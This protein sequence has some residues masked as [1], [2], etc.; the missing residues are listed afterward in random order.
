MQKADVAGQQTHDGS[1]APGRY[2]MEDHGAWRPSVK[3]TVATIFSILLAMAI[4]SLPRPALAAGA[5]RGQVSIGISV[6]FGPPPLPVYAQPYCPGP[7]YIWTPGYWAW[8][9]NTGYY[10]VPG[11]WVLAPFEGALWTPGYWGWDPAVALFMWHR[12]YWGTRVGFYG[13]IN[14]GFGYTGY[15]Y[16][17]GYWRDRHFYYN[18][19]VNRID[20]RRIR[21]VYDRRIDVRDESGISYNGGRGGIDA[22]PRRED[23]AARRY[24]R[25][26]PISSQMRQERMARQTP[27]MRW[28]QNRGRPDIAATP[29][30]EMFRDRGVSR[31]TRSGGE[32]RQ[33]Q[34]GFRPFGRQ[35]APQRQYRAP[36]QRYPQRQYQNQRPMNRNQGQ[37]QYHGPQRQ[38]QYRG[39]QGRPQQTQAPRSRGNQNRQQQQR[40]NRG[41]R[42]KGN[43]GRQGHPRN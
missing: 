21:R 35:P 42:G 7:G 4:V 31:A 43:Q 2:G 37:P 36:Q 38:P 9:A 1:E 39:Q 41:N 10:W 40:S 33:Q 3:I 22:R 16:D 20:V 19:A 28:S 11:T 13:G 25:M 27:G 24:R 6:G 17:G 30:P 12:G 15:G 26:G 32:Y 29:R 23:L 8:D 5:A 34:P 18:R 14:Y